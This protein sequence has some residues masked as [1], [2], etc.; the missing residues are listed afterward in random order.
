MLRSSNFTITRPSL[1]LGSAKQEKMRK[2]LHEAS[3]EMPD[4]DIPLGGGVFTMS[5]P[6]SA[7]TR[8]VRVKLA[9]CF[10]IF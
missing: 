10:G 4:I 2:E 3:T 1:L 8:I 6:S 9:R 7:M 5:L